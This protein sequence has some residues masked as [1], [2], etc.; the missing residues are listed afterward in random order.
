MLKGLVAAGFSDK[1]VAASDGVAACTCKSGAA[2]SKQ[3]MGRRR[4]A[5]TGSRKAAEQRTPHPTCTMPHA[6][7]LSKEAERQ[8]CSV[9]LQ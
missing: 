9:V 8:E 5:A 6:P 1:Q 4:H 7:Q 3:D 2:A